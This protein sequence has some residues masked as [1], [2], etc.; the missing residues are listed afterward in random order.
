LPPVL[1]D[2]DEAALL[3]A[4][5]EAALLEAEDEEAALDDDV[6]LDEEAAL[7]EVVLLDDDE[8]VVVLLDEVTALLDDAVE[9]PPEEAALLDP[10]PSP[11]VPVDPL[12]PFAHAANTALSV[13]TAQDNQTARGLMVVPLYL[14]RPHGREGEVPD[15]GRWRWARAAP[16]TSLLRRITWWRY[17]CE[18]VKF[19]AVIFDYVGVLVEMNRRAT[20]ELFQGR[21]LQSL[22][23]LIPKWE[24]WC[25]SHIDETLDA[26]EIWCGFW[27]SLGPEALIS[28][29]AR[30]AI[31]AFD[32]LSLFRAYPDTLP[33]L[34]SARQ[35]GLRLGVLSNSVLPKME[36][37]SAPLR[38][39]D[40]VTAICVPEPGSPFKPDG[41]AYLR[42]AEQLKVPAKMCLYFDNEPN[43]VE[44]ARRVG[45][46]GYLVDRSRVEHAIEQGVVKDLS[47]IDAL[48][49]L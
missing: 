7:D 13:A 8:V 47:A 29:E 37:P 33:A 30:E 23:V 25:A 46:T 24:Q 36:S 40:L 9:P 38:L 44:G 32:Y 26:R 15:R 11:P 42:I 4:E 19:E 39:S 14:S 18:L 17:S 41:A 2:E 20:D 35:R 3:E 48:L 49:D 21:V 31:H 43:L 10:A 28:A 34:T 6:P 1:L 5:D 12:S 22:R 27:D 45:M 16:R